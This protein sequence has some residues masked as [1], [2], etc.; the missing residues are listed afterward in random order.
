MADIYNIKSG[1]DIS[2]MFLD[3]KQKAKR[4]L[5]QTPH[6]RSK[7]PWDSLCHGENATILGERTHNSGPNSMSALIKSKNERHKSKS[8]TNIP[9]KENDKNS[10]NIILVYLKGIM[11][12]V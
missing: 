7:D 1:K 11:F 4:F 6:C 9:K 10:S 2:Y 3:E 5:Y 8:R 12:K